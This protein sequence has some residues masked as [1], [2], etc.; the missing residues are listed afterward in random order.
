MADQTAIADEKQKEE[1]PLGVEVREKSFQQIL[2]EQQESRSKP[3]DE[4]P[5]ETAEEK[6]AK[7]KEDE[8]KKAKDEDEAKSKQEADAKAETDRQEA[9]A[10][11]A[12]D[13]VI[14][15]QNEEKQKEL[16]KA[17]AEEEA[18]Q[19]EQ[20]LKPSWQVDPNAAKDAQGNPIP[21]SYDEIAAEAARIAT[22][23]ATAAVE[24]RER[25]KAAEAEK[26]AAEKTRNEEAI[27]TQ[28]KD[29]SDK[30]Q[31]ELDADISDLYA[32]NKLPKIKDPK[33]ENDPGVK[34][35][36]N[37]FETAQKVNAKRMAAG[38][39]PIR[40]IKL[41]FYEHYKPLKQPAG[42]DA[43][44]MGAEPNNGKE[45][46]DDKYIPARDRNKSMGQLLKEEAARIT[47]KIGV[48]SN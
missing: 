25:E 15:K 11:K 13:E 36:R 4:T 47:K 18:R 34:E 29:A 7:E 27:K 10:R 23:Q 31:S 44:V 40:S 30:L 9:I 41:I 48:R 20:K 24:A 28:Q 26:V 38:E 12:A 35:Y 22:E 8:K 37:L 14:A 5:I 46:P 21:K 2:K 1:K 33:N 43:P 42:H 45:L 17:K 32:A 16:D 19:Q 3:A 39:P 6:A